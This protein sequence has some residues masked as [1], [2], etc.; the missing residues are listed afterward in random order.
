[1]AKRQTR[2][3]TGQLVCVLAVDILARNGG[4]SATYPSNLA[5]AEPSDSLF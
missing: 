5:F 4:A 1:M 2:M 3:A